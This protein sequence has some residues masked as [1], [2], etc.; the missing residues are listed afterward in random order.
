MAYNRANH[1]RQ[2][3]PARDRD[4]NE[5][6]NFKISVEHAGDY[7]EWKDAFFHVR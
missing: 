2:V 4:V 5:Y 1:L 6:R 3:R 7:E